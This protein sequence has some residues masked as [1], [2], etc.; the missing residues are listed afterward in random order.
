MADRFQW[1]LAT[2][3][4]P[5]RQPVAYMTVAA[6]RLPRGRDWPATREGLTARINHCIGE[7]NRLGDPDAAAFFV[8][9]QED[10]S[11]G[12]SSVVIRGR[13]ASF[14]EFND[15]TMAVFRP[16]S[17][18]VDVSRPVALAIGERISLPA[19][20]SAD[21]RNK[22][23]VYSSAWADHPM[24]YDARGNLDAGVGPLGPARAE[25][26]HLF[27]DVPIDHWRPSLYSPGPFAPH[28]TL[29]RGD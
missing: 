14:A 11:D 25:F 16:V 21:P 13:R 29:G 5:L 17:T 6:T 27:L 19:V 22:I 15:R 9:Q 2:A 1:Y 10:Q 28:A 4:G 24:F 7:Y 8:F 3:F 12:A 18:E 26:S 23:L 20:S